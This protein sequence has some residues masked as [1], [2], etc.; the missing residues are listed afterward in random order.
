MSTVEATLELKK[1]L[2]RHLR[3]GHPWV[4]RKAIE[5]APRGLEAGAIVD[6]VEDGRFVARGYLDPHSAITVRILTREQ[7]ETV[8]DAFWR[9]RIRRALAL[10]RDLVHGTTGYR[11]VHGENDGLPGVVV[12]RYAGFAVVKLYSAGLTPHRARIV[13]ALR[14][15][16]DGLAGVFGRDEVPRDEESDDARPEGR[17]LWGAEPPSR[18][19]LTSTG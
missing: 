14:Q 2:V 5:K 13:E 10:R 9:G 18:S 17:V 16:V 19:R 12:D 15:E 6:V 11:L 8:D 1:D 3:A 4:F 7:A